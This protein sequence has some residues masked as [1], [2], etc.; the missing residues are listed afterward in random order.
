MLQLE[1]HLYCGVFLQRLLGLLLMSIPL[2]HHSS[3]VVSF[4]LVFHSTTIRFEIYQ[5][6][7]SS[8]TPPCVHS[9]S[10]ASASSVTKS[11]KLSTSPPSP[12]TCVPLTFFL[13]A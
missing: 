8:S 7:T 6:R 2:F 11:S 12:E 5:L 9:L 10:T 3:S 4:V 1:S 13:I